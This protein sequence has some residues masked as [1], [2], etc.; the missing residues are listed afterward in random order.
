MNYLTVPVSFRVKSLAYPPGGITV[1]VVIYKAVLKGFLFH[2]GL[3]FV[4]SCFVSLTAS[5]NS[6]SF[7]LSFSV[8]YNF[9][10]FPAVSNRQK[11]KTKEIELR[12]WVVLVSSTHSSCLSFFLSLLYWSFPSLYK[13]LLFSFF[14]SSFLRCFFLSS[15]FPFFVSSFFLHLFCLYN[16]VGSFSFRCFFRF[17]SLFSSFI[18]FFLLIESF[19]IYFL[20]LFSFFLSFFL[21]FLFCSFILFL[22]YLI[23][24]FF[25]WFILPF[26]PFSAILF[27][28]SFFFLSLF[29]IS[30]LLRGFFLYLF[31][32]FIASSLFCPFFFFLLF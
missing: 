31:F 6:T 28:P 11:T 17:S 19:I 14:T 2:G 23:S 8:F 4:L 9:L 22:F 25:L 18:L 12:N 3:I 10:L 15:L 13:L 21:S 5:W 30:F 1:N 20:L 16:F 24:S 7:L 27:F 26:F 32:S 29:V